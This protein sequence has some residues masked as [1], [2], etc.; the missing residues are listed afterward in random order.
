[1]STVGGPLGLMGGGRDFSRATALGPN[2]LETKI[3]AIVAGK[4]R[5]VLF[6]PTAERKRVGLLW[7]R[8]ALAGDTQRIGDA[9]ERVVFAP[10]QDQ[11]RT[12]WPGGLLLADRRPVTLVVISGKHRFPIRLG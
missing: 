12:V 8:S 3:P 1:M 2:T 11:P 4:K 9:F 7:G 6:V 10:C 5:A